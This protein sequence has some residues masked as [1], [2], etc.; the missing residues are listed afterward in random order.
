MTDF[1]ESY[2][3]LDRFELYNLARKYRQKVYKLI[4]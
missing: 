2:Y 1:Q 3:P 4:N